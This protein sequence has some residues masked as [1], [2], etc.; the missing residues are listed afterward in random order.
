MTS[1]NQ[2][3]GDC[4]PLEPALT[5]FEDG[6]STITV[7]QFTQVT[8][9]GDDGQPVTVNF[10]NTPNVRILREQALE[11]LTRLSQEMGMYDDDKPN[12]MV[13]DTDNETTS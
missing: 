13:K 5:T 2:S 6:L 3:A 9:T 4:Q 7:Q 12:P 11:E 8:Y 1:D 10:Q